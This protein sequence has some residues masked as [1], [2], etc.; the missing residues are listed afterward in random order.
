M[1]T[2]QQNFAEPGMDDQDEGREVNNVKLGTLMQVSEA[3]VNRQIMQAQ[4]YPRN[5]TNFRQSLQELS[6]YDEETALSCLYALKRE[7]KP[8]QGPSI[9]FAEAA[10]Q[11]WG[12]ARCGSRVV[13]IGDE[14]ITV[15]GFFWDLEKN[16]GLA[17]EVLRRITKRDGS[18]YG[19]D[20]IMVTG[21]AAGSI[22]VRNAILRGI[23]K[24]AWHPVY[25]KCRQ[26]SVGAGESISDKRDN[27]L[28]AFA[29]LNVDRAQILGLIG[30][31]GM[32]DV[33]ID[34]MI[35]MGGI[36]SSIKEGETT[37]E[38]A[39]AL[40]NMSHPDQVK[41]QAPRRSDFAG[42]DKK[43]GAKE[44]PPKETAKPAATTQPEPVAQTATEQPSTQPVDEYGPI[45]AELNQKLAAA[46]K[47]REVGELRNAGI[48]MGVFS[49]EQEA[50]WQADCSA[51]S[52]AI[53]NSRI[54]K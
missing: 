31:K 24:T 4:A 45:I 2:Q 50:Q 30:V 35:F 6:C 15:Q 14:F 19:E 18:R 41:P 51:R 40:E 28:K 7:N 9:R 13:D 38:Q 52:E 10:F 48:D 37:V 11:T 27:M 1:N 54:G 33:T 21:N 47:I 39:F 42:S 53:K 44:T 34:H 17:F 26:V 8:I 3:E 36:L 22:A 16:T 29:P 32:D 20:M 5:V 49:P 46:T 12:N 43:G 25:Q 23:P